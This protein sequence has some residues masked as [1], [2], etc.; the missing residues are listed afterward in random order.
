MIKPLLSRSLPLLL[1]LLGTACN[2]G[3][4]AAD[5]ATT[6]DNGNVAEAPADSAAPA[7]TSEPAAK[8]ETDDSAQAIELEEFSPESGGFTVMAPTPMTENSQQVETAVG[9]IEVY[10]FAAQRQDAAYIV[11]YSDYPAEIVAQND[12]A[13]ML[14]GSRDG[15]LRNVGGTLVSEESIE[16]NGNPGRAVTISTTVGE[17]QREA[18]VNA[19]LFLV[20]NRLYQLLVVQP[21]A[22]DPDSAQSFLESFSL[23]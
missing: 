11:A 10:T 22:A 6:E 5:T 16:L 19:R 1:L 12:P 4:P 17:S 3:E 14:D 2:G 8:S 18:V 23:Q 13:T 21:A 9:P 15:A 20:D 7:E